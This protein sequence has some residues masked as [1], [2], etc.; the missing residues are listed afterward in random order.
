M[1]VDLKEFSMAEILGIAEKSRGDLVTLRMTDPHLFMVYGDGHVI[2]ASYRKLSGEEAFLSALLLDEG[3]VEITHLSLDIR[4]RPNITYVYDELLQE[5]S[6]RVEE[7]RSMMAQLGSLKV[8]P[9]V[10]RQLKVEE[11]CINALHWGII[12]GAFK[13]LTVYYLADVLRVSEYDLAKAVL[14]L[15]NVGAITMS[16]GSHEPVVESVLVEKRSL[17]SQRLSEVKKPIHQ[18]KEGLGT[19][20]LVGQPHGRLKEIDF[21]E[22]N[23]KSESANNP[24]GVPIKTPENKKATL[25]TKLPDS[26]G[27]EVTVTVLPFGASLGTSDTIDDGCLA[28]NAD[29]F[30]MIQQS[31]GENS[32]QAYILN[33]EKEDIEPLLVRLV[34]TK[35]V[36]SAALTVGAFLKLGARN[37]QTVKVLPLTT[38]SS[39]SKEE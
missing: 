22:E 6:K 5:G 8:V 35:Q 9:K 11:L 30:Q 33:P 31:L 17:G 20:L 29:V 26:K 39:N 21:A 25:H 13:G 15:V 12:V 38:N 36:L 34:P 10:C 19:T 37:G 27:I 3:V 7:F 23:V 1:L 2:Y 28:L 16:E 14:D 24:K 4:I 32:T 18:V